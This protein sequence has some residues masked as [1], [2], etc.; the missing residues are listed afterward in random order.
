MEMAM[1]VLTVIVLAVVHGF[2]ILL[3]Y[4]MGRS[5]ERAAHR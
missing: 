2:L 1:S 3:G 4:G 5:A